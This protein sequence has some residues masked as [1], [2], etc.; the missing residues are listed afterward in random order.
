[1][2]PTGDA[3]TRKAPKRIDAELLKADFPILDERIHGKRLAY[4]D[5]AATTQK[6]QCVLDAITYFYSTE[7]SNVHRGLHELS[8]RATAAYE[9][10]REIVRG[11]LNARATKEIVFVRGT[12]EAVNLVAQS[13]GGKHVGPGD[14]VVITTME[15]H[16]NIVP[17]Q[18]L[19]EAKGA[20]LKVAPIDDAGDIILEDFESLLG[21]KTRIVAVAHVS[22]ALGTC[23]PVRTII[24]MAHARGIPVLLDGAQAAP[25]MPI[26]VQELDC[27]FYAFSGHKIYGPSGI[28]VLYGKAQLLDSMPPYQG[29]GEMIRH[30]TFEKTL[31]NE[32]PDRFEAGTPNISGAVGLGVALDYISALGLD[33][34]EAHEH[35][36]LAALT[37]ALTD[38]PGVTIVGT[39]KEKAGLVSFV[40]DGIHPHDIGTILDHEGVAIRAGHHC[41]QP[42][43]DRYSVS[44]TARASLGLYNTREDIDALIAG[45]HKVR[46]VFL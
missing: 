22:N 23:N 37:E 15:H 5:N 8:L 33:A 14:E 3:A 25:R 31:Y 29:G 21:P 17:W 2:T 26:D 34:I 28:G 7:Y 11:F 43:M 12:T 1:M 35:T 46:E 4:L 10:A 6:P 40:V 30:V 42:T 13:Y 41:A 19:C 9:S 27:D 36:L 39:A 44:A 45:M 32:I 16:S 24:E 18:M 38:L 20:H